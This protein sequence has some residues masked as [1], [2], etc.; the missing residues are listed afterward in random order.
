MKRFVKNTTL[1]T[2]FALLFGACLAFV[3]PQVSQALVAEGE[4][5]FNVECD[6]QEG[7]DWS[8]DA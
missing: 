3:T 4:N 6:G 8:W 2:M 7:V 5:P 1:L